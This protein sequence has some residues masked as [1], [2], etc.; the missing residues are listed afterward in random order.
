MIHGKHLIC[1]QIRVLAARIL[2]FIPTVQMELLVARVLIKIG[3]IG[4]S[5]SL[6]YLAINF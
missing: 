1:T 3:V 2:M 6:R 4:M 5:N